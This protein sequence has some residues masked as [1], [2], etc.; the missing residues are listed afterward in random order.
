MPNQPFSAYYGED[1][2]TGK[3]NFVELFLRKQRQI[4]RSN[5]KKIS[6]HL[7]IL[8]FELKELSTNAK[9]QSLKAFI[10]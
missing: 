10:G 3:K 2:Q 5:K 1:W 8:I 6:I 4:C 7:I 9:L